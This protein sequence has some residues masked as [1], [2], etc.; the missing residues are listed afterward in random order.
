VQPSLCVESTSRGIE[1]HSDAAVAT[2]VKGGV[3]KKGKSGLIG[4]AKDLAQALAEKERLYFP[5]HRHG[6]AV[7]KALGVTFEGGVPAQHE[8]YFS[9]RS[10][11]TNARRWCS[12]IQAKPRT[13]QACCW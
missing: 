10:T 7:S 3:G 12:L 6:N 9:S 2:A 1:T 8:V 11:R 13:S 5:E 4:R